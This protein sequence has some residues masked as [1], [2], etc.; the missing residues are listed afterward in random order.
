M[1]RIR[2]ETPPRLEWIF[3]VIMFVYSLHK[4]NRGAPHPL[5]E[6]VPLALRG[7]CRQLGGSVV[8]PHPL[9]RPHKLRLCSLLPG[10][11]A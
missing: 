10:K 2:G 8:H 9:P 5:A 1:S 7:A 11:E 3:E 4:F 6:F